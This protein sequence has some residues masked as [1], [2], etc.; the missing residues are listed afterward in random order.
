M[1][2]FLSS[3]EEERLLRVFRFTAQNGYAYEVAPV[4][5]VSTMFYQD[6]GLWQYLGTEHRGR[7][8]RTAIMATAACNGRAD[9][10]AWLLKGLGNKEL[11]AAVD[12]DGY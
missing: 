7:K 5:Y 3:L 10:L 2:A 4:G 12:T 6:E 11:V 1:A 9:R 8:N